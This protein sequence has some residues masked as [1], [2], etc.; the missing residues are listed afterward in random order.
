M[1]STRELGFL[2]ANSSAKFRPAKPDPSTRASTDF[3]V[4][5]G[6]LYNRGVW[7]G[8]GEGLVLK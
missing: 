8:I 6:D 7:S 2:S 1:S 3:V 5:M 4:C